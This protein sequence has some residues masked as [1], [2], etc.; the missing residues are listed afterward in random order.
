MIPPTNCPV[1]SEAFNTQDR[2]PY[3][4]D[5]GPFLAIDK[6]HA[7]QFIE[8]TRPNYQIILRIFGF[9]INFLVEWKWTG[10]EKR[11]VA[12]RQYP[13]RD[14]IVFK[15]TPDYDWNKIITDFPAVHKKL[16]IWSTFG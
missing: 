1:C 14:T 8:L 16:S 6:R 15:G 11:F 9:E 2:P 10:E 4:C 7:F 13:G 3:W 5:R 12:I